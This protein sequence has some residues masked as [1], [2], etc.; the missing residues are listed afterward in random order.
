MYLIELD[1]WNIKQGLPSKP[2]TNADYIRADANIQGI[3]NAIQYASANGFTKIVLPRGQY[4]I[5]Y[6]REIKMVS[7]ITFDLNG[8]ILKVIYDS[9]RKSPFDTRTTS[10]YYSFK[11]NSILF[12]NVTNSHLVGGTIIGCRDD[13]SFQNSAE[14]R[15]EHTYG[16]VFQRSTRFSSIKNCIVRDYMGDNITFT[17][18]AVR[19]VAVFNASL[20]TLNYLTGQVSPSTNTLVTDFINIPIGAEFSS[21]QIAGFGYTRLTALN[22]KE[23]DIF[24]YRADNSFIGVLKKRKI[25]TDISIPLGATKIR[26]LFSKETN[27]TK[28]LQIT[29]KFGLIPHHN[30]VEYNEVFNGHRGGITLG[31]SYNVIQHNVVR[32]NGKGSNSFLDGKPIFGYTTRYAINQE[33][34]YG[35]NCVIRNNLIYGSYHGI[36]VG[37]YSIQI[38]NNHI[39]DIDAIGINLYST[40]YAN[41][42]GNTFHNC[43]NSIGLMTSNFNNSFVNIC[44]NNIHGGGLSLNSNNSYTI[45][46]SDNNFIDV[47]YIDTG[48]N[49]INNIFRNNR[50]KFDG[51]SD[52]PTINV[53]NID[54]CHFESTSEKEITFRVYKQTRCA[55]NNIKIN[56]L[57]RNGS[58]M[59]EKV[60]I[61]NCEFNNSY[62]IN[63]ILGTKNREIS[64]TNSRFTDSVIKVGNINTTGST[65][66][67]ILKN[68][69]LYIK[70]NNKLFATDANKSRGSIKLYRC[71][72]EISNPNFSHLILNEKPVPFLT[73]F[74][75]ESKFNYIGS[76]PLK[77][78]YYNSTIP[79]INF[80]SSNNVFNNILLP[81][82]DPGIF[83]GY[84]INNTY[85]GNVSLQFDSNKYSA[86]LNHNLNTMDPYVMTVTDTSTIIQPSVSIIDK[87]SIMIKHPE[88]IE[89]IVIVKRL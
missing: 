84:D 29:L 51:V 18:S 60:S 89:L 79:M 61:D 59:N 35:D 27:A 3:N 52:K 37:C 8:S 80:I 62:L 45:N 20:N 44:E 71:N 73:L 64:V 26:M 63:H 58:T 2:Y 77:L 87:D 66:T 69:D 81:A 68:C 12:E 31:G 36:L 40:L 23:V 43:P 15:M 21:F 53:N 39:Y 67:T 75:K 33:D 72:I 76:S 7:G 42:K 85:K 49:N 54:G 32:D 46:I 55:F 83:I 57:T 24:F 10:D 48:S 82:E 78:T 41:V 47:S 9:D 1:R 74:I 19:E 56:I 22:S 25:Y 13:R 16:V 65:A 17:S 30:L 50:I 6:P 11:G 4:A 14:V 86:I 5:C 28:N 34:S 70:T 38:E 88:N